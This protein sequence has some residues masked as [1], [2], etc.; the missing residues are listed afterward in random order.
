MNLPSFLLG[1]A[2]ALLAIFFMVV[3]AFMQPAQGAWLVGP[4]LPIVGA[5]L[6]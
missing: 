4:R 3:M 6:G 1:T 2:F 5:V